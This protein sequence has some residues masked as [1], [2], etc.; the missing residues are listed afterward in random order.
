[1]W[2]AKHNS[3]I[4]MEC[5]NRIYIIKYICIYIVP[6]YHNVRAFASVVRILFLKFINLRFPEATASSKQRNEF[7]IFGICPNCPLDFN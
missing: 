7:Y 1:M 4:F 3:D 6:I 2:E 5:T